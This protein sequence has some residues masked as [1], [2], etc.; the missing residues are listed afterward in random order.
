MNSGNE[1]IKRI[2]CPPET[3]A[4][5]Y[6]IFRNEIFKKGNI[7]VNLGKDEKSDEKVVI[8]QTSIEQYTT[9]RRNTLY[10]S[11]DLLYKIRQTSQ[12]N[13]IVPCL[14]YIYTKVNHY[15][16]M[17]YYDKGNLKDLMNVSLRK[18]L[19]I[20]QDMLKAGIYLFENQIFHGK[21]SPE[22]F[23]SDGQTVYLLGSSKVKKIDDV[24][25]GYDKGKFILNPPFINNL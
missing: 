7:V 15:L 8:K 10:S 1:V 11:S 18:K 22:K 14:N 9:K 20:V 19:Q 24:S 13:H 5:T 4:F 21:V 25:V 3:R 23:L 6:L 17:P 2:G 16:I 12:A